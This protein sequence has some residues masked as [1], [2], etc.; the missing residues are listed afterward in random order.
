MPLLLKIGGG[1]QD[2]NTESVYQP[3]CSPRTLTIH[4]SNPPASLAPTHS[5]TASASW[6]SRSR[7]SPIVGAEASMGEIA[8]P[9]KIGP[10]TLYRHFATRDDLLAT[11]YI[12]EVEKLAAAQKKLSAE[13]PPSRPCVRGYWSSLTISP[14]KRSLRR[15]LTQWP[16]AL[17]ACSSRP[18]G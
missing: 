8:R 10:G 17:R 1:F 15:H 7:S 11:V 13:F 6:K 4:R 5:A 16:A 2:S 12:T 3:F 18:R 9:S 14:R